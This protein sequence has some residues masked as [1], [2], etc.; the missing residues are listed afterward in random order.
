MLQIILIGVL[1]S[2]AAIYLGWLVYRSFTASS[3]ESGCGKCGTINV[4]SILKSIE[5]KKRPA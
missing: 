1:L 3:C 5:E 2:G 4:E